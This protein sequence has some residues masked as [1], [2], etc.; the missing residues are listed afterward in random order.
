MDIQIERETPAQ[1]PVRRVIL[2]LNREEARTLTWLCG[3]LS[4]R[5]TCVS[6][7]RV[8][9]GTSEHVREKLTSPIYEKLSSENLG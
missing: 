4:G 6:P 2:T 7:L 1:P 3:Q 9:P 8:E 5:G